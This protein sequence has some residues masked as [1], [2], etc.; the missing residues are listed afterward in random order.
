MGGSVGGWVGACVRACAKC[1]PCTPL[2]FAIIRTGMRN[3]TE[4]V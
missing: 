2:S 1:S 4:G 3:Q